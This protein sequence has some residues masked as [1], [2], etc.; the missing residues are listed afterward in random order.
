M[1][2]WSIS[3]AG[4]RILTRFEMYLHRAPA[5][6][7]PASRRSS[8][9]PS[10]GS[11]SVRVLTLFAF[12]SISV[13]AGSAG[14]PET[15]VPARWQGGPLELQRRAENKT[16]PSDPAVRESIAKWYDPAT[17]DVL[18][19]TPINCLLVTWGAEGS[20]ETVKQQHDLVRSYAGEAHTRGLSV[21]GLISPGGDPTLVAERSAE[22]GLD[23]LVVEGD[24]GDVVR[25]I[26]EV[27]RV[28]LQK[29]SAAVVFPLI[30]A[31]KLYPDP[32]W[33]ILAA[34]DAVVPGIQEL[35]EGAETAPSSEPWIESN[36]WLIRSIVSWCGRRSVWLGE[37]VVANATAGDYERAVAD[38][39]AGGGQ[40]ILAPGDE[41]RHGL[42]LKQPEA[43]TTWRRISA[44]LKFHQDH[45]RW[46]RAAPFAVMGFIQDRSLKDR[47]VSDENLNLACR[48]RIPLFLINRVKLSASVLEGLSAVHAIDVIRP[49]EEER[50]ILEGFA[51]KGGLVVI[52]PSWKP[53]EIPR[54]QDFAV[55]PAGS[56]RVVVYREDSPDPASLSKDLV[57]LLGRD[58]LGVRLFRGASVLINTS[59][60]KANNRLL[61]HLLNYA[62]EPADALVL[63]ITGDFG[64]ASLITPERAS[65][66]LALEKSGGRVE[67][68][69]K[70]LSVYGVISLEK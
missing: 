7:N 4:S 64:K 61:V 21:L 28:L 38:A 59:V 24:S 30:A 9:T 14:G 49:T 20:T 60:D 17:L 11:I 19:D 68:S 70:S 54:N 8:G 52:G 31:E 66:E 63:R 47:T 16:L 40:W 44:S 5:G 29:R 18:K 27:R 26:A 37:G 3:V 50:T 39:A 25:F 58:N 67:V 57:D 51:Q 53:V 62:S 13:R 32:D 42:L 10:P 12:A 1:R 45:A 48:S 2:S 69:I 55:L 34:A 35:S 41:L 33:P 36:I 6:A 65:E 46:H 23:G 22:A 43:L 56:G 15:W